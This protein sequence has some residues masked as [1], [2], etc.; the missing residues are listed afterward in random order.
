MGGGGLRRTRDVGQ[1]GDIFLLLR[2]PLGRLAHQCIGAERHG[3]V[4]A[5]P[6]WQFVLQNRLFLQRYVT[7]RI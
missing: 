5:S 2:R 3:H 7:L 4:T 1:S 6:G